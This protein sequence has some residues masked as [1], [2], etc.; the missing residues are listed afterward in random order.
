MGT[1]LPVRKKSNGSKEIIKLPYSIIADPPVI[2]T[3][4]VTTNTT[5]TVTGNKIYTGI[6]TFSNGKFSIRA[7]SVN[8]DSWIQLTNSSNNAYYA[9]GIRRPYASYGLQLKYHPDS[10]NQDASRPGD[11]N[12]TSDIYYDIYHRGNYTKIPAATKNANGL[13][14][15]E[16]KERFDGLV[17]YI[18]ITISG[19]SGTLSSSELKAIKDN[20]HKVVINRGT[21]WYYAENLSDTTYFYT[22]QNVIYN[23]NEIQKHVLSINPTSGAWSYQLYKYTPTFTDTKVTQSNTTTDKWRKIVLGSQAETTTGTATSEQ[24][25][26]VYVT[27]NIEVQASTGTLKALKIVTDTIEARDE[28]LEV[29]GKRRLYLG[30]ENGGMLQLFSSEMEVAGT[31]YVQI[32]VDDYSASI[33]LLASD[34]DGD[35]TVDSNRITLS[36]DEVVINEGA[37]SFTFPN[38]SGT[39]ATIEEVNN[40]IAPASEMKGTLGEN[41]TIS[42]LPAA[43]KDVA[44]DMYKVIT[45]G[46]YSN[47]SAKVGDV[48]ICYTTDN[49]TYQ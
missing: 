28:E 4:Y 22:S 36:A 44:G 46:T 34:S 43:S 3:N 13:M 37:N 9:F 39:L 10:T 2:P 7:N 25:N 45:A 8:D 20:P 15:K 21:I 11:A 40:L 17:D 42:A 26:Q 49:S 6:N 31:D 48:F 19:D 18:K 38:S 47:I 1:Y 35:G 5:Q 12:G 32:G 41:G 27:P 29:F 33:T 30:T 14:T 16:D 23:G 24:T